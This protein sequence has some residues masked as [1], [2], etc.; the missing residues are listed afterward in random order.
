M[1]DTRLYRAPNSYVFNIQ[2]LAHGTSMTVTGVTTTP[3]GNQTYLTVAL[4]DLETGGPVPFG[5]VASIELQHAFGTD[6]GFTSFDY[7]LDTS[8]WPVGTHTVTV[9]L[10]ILGGEPYN[11]PSNYQF[12]ITIRS[13]STVMYHDPSPLNF[14]LGADF[15]VDL[16]LNVSEPG[17]NY[18]NP[19]TG[20]IA[21]EFSVPGYV[22]SIG[23]TEQAVGR[24]KLSISASYFTGGTY[25]IIVFF[26]SAD[27]VYANTFVV[28]QF[29]YREVDSTLTSPNYPQV[30]TPY[31]LDVKIVLN[32]TDIDFGSGIEGATITSPDHPTWIANWSDNGF[33]IYGVWIDV[34]TLS[35]G[36]YYL[37]LTADKS[38]I[39]AKTLEFRIVIRS[40]YTSVIPTVG[41]L[42]IPIGNSYVFYAEFTDTDR[43]IPIDN[44]SAPY[45]LVS[46]TW[47][48]FSVVYESLSDM[49]RI[50]FYTSDSDT[51]SQNI[52]YTFTFSKG[53]NYQV[54]EFTI[55]VSIRTHNTD[56]RIVSSIEPTSTI[57][58]FNI[59]V[60]YGDLDNAIGVKS[61]SVD[62]WVEN[63]SGVVSS[64]YAYDLILGDG[65]Y[66]IQVPAA[67]FGLGLQTL[68]VHADWTGVVAIY[69]D[70][71]FVT[72]ANVVGRES[73]L[74]LLV[75]SAPTPYN[76][77]MAYTF[78]YS[79]LFSSVGI[80][81]LTGNVFIY[82]SFTGESVSP[83]DVV[84]VDLSLTEAGN[85]SIQ[86]NTGIFSRT[87]LIYMNV[88]VNWSKGVSPYYA[89][90]TDVVSLT[91]LRRDTLLSIS[92]P[93]ATSYNENATFTLTFE[94]IGTSTLI[95]GLTKDQ[96]ALNISFSLTETAGV[97]TISFNTN[98]YPSLGTKAIR[99][100]VTWTGAPFYASRIGRITYINIIYRE[101]Y[102]EYLTPPPTPYGDQVIFNVTWT[103]ITSGASDPI[104]SATLELRE[105]S[106][107]I[108]LAEYSYFEIAPG[109]Y[110]VTLNTTYVM[111]PGTDT[112]R[113]I[114]SAG[115]FYIADRTVD[116]LFTVDYRLT[117][118]AANPV[119]DVPYNSS[120]LITLNYL[121]Q[122]TGQSITNDSAHV[123]ILV[124]APSGAVFTSSWIVQSQEYELVIHWNPSWSPILW[125]P[126]TVH[127]FTVEMSYDSIAPFYDA[128]T[129]SGT[130]KIRI[131]DSTLA[132]DTEPETTPYLD[133]AI[134]ILDY[135]DDDA[136]GTGIEGALVNILDNNSIPLNQGV[137]YI[138]SDAG[139]FYTITV[140]STALGTL[141]THTLRVQLNWSGA[142]YHENVTRNVNVLVRQRETNLDI[143]VPPSQ[144][145]YFDDV[146]FTFQYLD[147]DADIQITTITSTNIRLRWPNST[148]INSILYTVNQVGGLYEIIISS[149]VLSTSTVSGLSLRVEIDWDGGT[150]PYYK[151]DSTIVKITITRR[152][153]LVETSQIERTPKGDLLNISV[154]ITDLDSELPVDNAIILFS[155]RFNPSMSYSSATGFGYYNFTIDT[156]TL[157]GTGTF[158][159]DIEIQWDPTR[160]PFYANR[161]VITLTGLVDLVRTTFTVDIITPSS[162][163]YTGTVSLLVTWQDLDHG[164][165]MTGYAGIL[166]YS[167]NYLAG[168]RPLLLNVFETGT[169]GEYNITFST[170]DRTIGAHTLVIIAEVSPYSPVTVTP[171]F[172]V[173]PINTELTPMVTSITD[174]WKN[175][176][177]ISVDY[178]DLFNGVPIS[179]AASVTWSYAPLS[180]GGILTEV[181]STGTYEG[182]V[183]TNAFEAGTFVLTITA[184]KS[185]YSTAIT[186]IT[187]VVLRIP[188][189][190]SIISPTKLVYNVSRGDPVFVQ[191]E[192]MDP[193]SGF[194]IGNT[195]VLNESGNYQVYAELKSERY[196]MLYDVGNGLW[197]VTI[198]GSATVLE[199]LLSYDVQIFAGF[200]NY[201]PAVAQFTLYIQQASTQLKVIGLPDPTKHEVYYLQEV[202]IELN[203]TA[204]NLDMLIDN[205]SVRWLD[206]TRN[207]SL[208]FTS[209]GNGIWSLTFNTSILGFGTVGVSFYG[210]P[211]NS[212]LADTLTSMTLTVKKIPTSIDGPTELLNR[213]WG[214]QGNIALNFSDDYNDRNVAGATVT[215]NYGNLDFNATDL[216]NGTY[217]LY[218]D[219]T[220]LD[221]GSR[222]KISTSFILA[223][224]EE[225]S[226]SFYIN[227]EE[228]PTELIVSYP[229]Q[230]HVSFIED[231][232][233]LELTMGDAIDISLFYNDT[234]TI[235]GL[236]GGIEGANFTAY[237]ELRA[238]SYFSGS[239][240]VVFI[241]GFGYY[242]FT[243]DTNDVTLY[244]RY[245]GP[246]ILEG[247]YFT[248][249]IE[250][251]SEH[252]ALQKIEIRIR[253]IETP[254]EII[255][256]GD[257]V[258]PDTNIVYTITNGE[259]VVFD[260]YIRDTW[261]DVG[262]P[263]AS[264]SFTSGAT[265]IISSNTTLGAGNYRLIIRAVDYG[266]DSL[267]T[268]T[269]STE[270]HDDVEM[271]FLIHTEP[272]DFDILFRDFTRIGLPISLFVILLLGAYVRVWSVPKRIRQIN[273]QLKALRKGKVPKPIGDVKSRQQLAAELFNDTFSEFKIT[274]TAAQMPE[275]A[276]PIEV[277]E[278]GELLMQLAILTNL[279]QAELD[280]FQ[281]D[282]NKMKMSE[283]AAFVKEVIMQEAIRAARRDGKTIEET[284]ATVEQ[285]AIR[286]LGGEEEIAPVEVVEPEETETVFLEEGKEAE[287]T[288]EKSLLH[289]DE[290]TE[291][292]PEVASEKMSLYEIEELRRDLERR[293]VPP[294]EIDTI[295]EQAKELPRELVDELV[296]SLEGKKD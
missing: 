286:R 143:T 168:G 211:A 247:D 62:F 111:G 20:R 27:N 229:D 44:S 150:A 9:V 273:G 116:R 170:S 189:E 75:G 100:D 16:R 133:D 296:K 185:S 160:A 166:N 29:L 200:K 196:Y 261:H 275:D 17:P 278:M 279:S 7:V 249:T 226:F 82:V 197:N 54:A 277:P 4:T 109:I 177:P 171:Q 108:N 252:R 238:P 281:A 37:N 292:G 141:G 126:G 112:L 201:D 58:I 90:R 89:N 11:N 91:V 30:T 114:I 48:N 219:T 71:S 182:L 204:P 187:L 184:T 139:G 195:A 283:Q 101:T 233:T 231:V 227:V 218:I 193:T 251:F 216:G 53:A 155:C 237:T 52:V 209:M 10:T 81:N 207:I 14:P 88:F 268:V 258:D 80:D 93:S 250:I 118:V 142:P 175:I 97:Y 94:D 274:R 239:R 253:I 8:A 173:V 191:I 267:L 225:R 159:F 46:S 266:G 121:D 167:I 130:F 285:E 169:L 127:D 13:M 282:I 157:L 217:V 6:S 240:T 186:T 128:D 79:D 15:S 136:S 122:F 119:V 289:K 137:D 269:L 153:M 241:D 40:A 140:H 176:T 105:G 85:Y 131:R 33:G 47:G 178:L 156:S 32:Y 146:S 190:M 18:G 1:A 92:P 165:P 49:Y 51:I 65:F 84:I 174:Y 61:A 158:L 172:S 213:V 280:E 104:T 288:E 123:T 257:V 230:N 245:P 103:D 287:V 50:T 68:T 290:V 36:I 60:Y 70:K 188:S 242:N 163:Q 83:D 223:N 264:Y 222:E 125:A 113:I 192:L 28:I 254:T 206:S 295:V 31:Q 265:A 181:G 199:A 21:G 102:F 95:T 152:T 124:T 63:A 86:F 234:N 106:T 205:A 256:D 259:E 293:G 45:T 26:T 107:P 202:T 96:I 255:F 224:Y 149:T 55:T 203:F 134:F 56:F 294:H 228:R 180:L 272:N 284:L 151:D 64:S 276:I 135:T 3:Y 120:I 194:P 25:Q 38:G 12:Q 78:L 73:A 57:G 243:F 144:T 198:P 67:Q 145:L 59:S 183:D 129:V 179:S 260:F 99:I 24:Y 34:S 215:F 117:V 132:L 72:T 162:V 210:S 248:Y 87:G 39:I 138:V 291:E 43:L 42:N 69:Q 263:S 19:I 220:I 154:L 161:S 2:I 232:I 98:Q 221:S 235:G 214:W 41:S 110:Q 147:V 76:E 115:V 246:T 244:D 35:Q 262:V 236:L 5:S 22:I 66:I 74:T 208:D 164:V 148:V 77:D 23:T 271:S 212:T 270:F